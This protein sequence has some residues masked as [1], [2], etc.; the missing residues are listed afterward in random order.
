MTDHTENETRPTTFGISYP[1][2]C[3]DIVGNTIGPTPSGYLQVAAAEYDAAT[4]KTHATLIPGRDPRGD[5]VQWWD[6]DWN[7]VDAPENVTVTGEG[8]L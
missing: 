6:R 4:D 7:R 3:V 1:G 5:T 8:V 2:N